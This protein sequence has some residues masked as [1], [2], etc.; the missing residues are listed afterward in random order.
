MRTLTS[1][2][3]KLRALIDR[4]AER[5]GFDVVAVTSPDS[6]PLAP[7]R[8]AQFVAEGFHGTMGW[9]EETLERRGD[10]SALW[11]EV[12]S[13]IVLAMNY[14]PDHDPRDLLARR[15]RGAI[16]VYA[17]NRD[18]HDVMK[19]RLKEIAG[20]IVAKA[21]GDV[22]VF[23]D[24]APVMEKPLAEAAGVGWQGKH[25]NLVSREHGSWLFLGSIFTTADLMADEREADRCGSCRACLD[26]C[27]TNAFPAPYRLDARRCISY[28]TIENKGPIPLEFREAIGNRIYGCDDCLA[29]C[30]WNKFAQVASEAKL[31]AREDL[32]E[33]SLADL[34]ALDDA[35]FRSFFS[36]SPVKRIGRDRFIRNVL[37]AAG[38]S[39][40][41]ALVEQARGLLSDGSPLVRGAAVWALSRLMSAWDFASLANVALEMEGD[42]GVCEEW[43]QALGNSRQE[44]IRG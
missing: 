33:P 8:L 4:E 14:G 29:A 3:E 37:V 40:D 13:V 35:A 2:V 28:L 6:I 23:V 7:A 36:G 25:T 15:D 5:A 21:G 26:A 27:P 31:A 30:P 12:R 22:K 42:A 32:R 44:E 17:R 39:G 24:T 16:S 9:M 1:E 11:P 38:N 34:V 43:R 19:G 18:Y 10:P 41:P 20:K